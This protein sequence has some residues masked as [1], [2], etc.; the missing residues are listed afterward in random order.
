MYTVMNDLL[1]YSR[2]LRLLFVE[3]NDEARTYIH[4]M[5][6]RFFD[7]ITIA[8][9]GEEGLL[10]FKDGTFDLIMS[11]IN[12]PGM[13]GVT[14]LKTIKEI[15]KK[16]LVIILSAHN[17]SGYHNIQHN[18]GVDAYLRKPLSLYQLTEALTALMYRQEDRT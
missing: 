6:S 7:C 12:M 3:D 5:L 17:D 1:A 8:K 4:E 2:G 9:N 18:I 13:N 15:D 10:K 16:I 14:M 11:D